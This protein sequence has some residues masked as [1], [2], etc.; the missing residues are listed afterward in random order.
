MVLLPLYGLAFPPGHR[1]WLPLSHCFTGPQDCVRTTLDPQPYKQRVSWDTAPQSACHPQGLWE[2]R[3]LW[4]PAKSLEQLG[5]GQCRQGPRC[6]HF[7][8]PSFR[9][10]L[11]QNTPDVLL[12][13]GSN[14]QFMLLQPRGFGERLELNGVKSHTQVFIYSLF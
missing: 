8:V 11:F 2:P 9:V 10:F 1:W 14:V 5:P 12:S 13:L 4:E 3:A 6:H 7:T